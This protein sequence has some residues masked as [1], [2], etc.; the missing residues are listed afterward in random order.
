MPATVLVNQSARTGL[1]AVLVIAA[2]IVLLIPIA[3]SV[4]HGASRLDYTKVESSE[5]LAASARD[6]RFSLDTGASITVRT[7]DADTATVTMTGVGPRDDVPKLRVEETN[8]ESVVTVDDRKVFENAR[9]AVA[10]PKA[11]SKDTNLTFAGG[12]G[13]VDV[14]GE[15]NDVK[16][17]T[18]AGSVSLEGDFEK[19]QTTTDWGQTRFKGSFGSIEAK[20]DVG[21]LE[22]T[23]LKVRDRVDATT[24]TGSI[25]LDFSNEMVPTSGITVKADEGKIDLRL[26]RL[27]LVKEHMSAE[28]AGPD[29]GRDGS[30]DGG[31]EVKDLF[32]RINATSNQGSV[33]LAK[34]LEKYDAS[35]DPK[36]A[37]GK[38]VI[39]VSV[40][41]DTGAITIDQ[42]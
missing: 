42:N 14:R 10:I 17:D 22:G 37:E 13:E 28:A 11:T 25:D 32:Y 40:T 18:D 31:A 27:D 6:V 2:A 16:A 35:K 38:A 5:Q 34:D 33:D 19:V 8:G 12:L 36:D 3:I 30:D 41:A 23:D 26:P 21:T 7:T 4:A 29:D 20:S 1:R 39:P 15:F 24:S 9:I